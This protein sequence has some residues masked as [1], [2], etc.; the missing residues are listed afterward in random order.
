MTRPATTLYSLLTQD[1]KTRH[2]VLVIRHYLG[3]KFNPSNL[4]D[5]ARGIWP[6]GETPSGDSLA[7]TDWSELAALLNKL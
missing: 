4:R 5:F 6:N 3:G 1:P 7:E 2:K